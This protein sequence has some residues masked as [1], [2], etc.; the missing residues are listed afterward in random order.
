MVGGWELHDGQQITVF[1]HSG[2][3]RQDAQTERNY[4]REGYVLL[5]TARPPREG[6]AQVV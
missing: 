4:L 3:H 1:A 6:I 2:S 5:A